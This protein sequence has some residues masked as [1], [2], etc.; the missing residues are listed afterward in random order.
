MKPSSTSSVSARPLLGYDAARVGQ[1]ADIWQQCHGYPPASSEEYP[2]ACC[3][4]CAKTSMKRASSAGSAEVSVSLVAGK[5]DSLRRPRAT[6]RLNPP[7]T[8]AVYGSS[9]EADRFGPERGVWY[10]QHDAA[11]VFVDEVIVAGELK[12]LQ[13]AGH[14]E[15]EGIATPAGKKTVIA[16]V[17]HPRLPVHGDRRSFDDYVPTLVGPG[18]LCALDRRN[19]AAARR[20]RMQRTAR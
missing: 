4:E 13:G 9:P 14:I 1:S 7:A 2:P 17:R 6:I 19:V 16:P 12:A 8:C 20:P 5:E 3:N 11:H 18:G 15:E 10:F